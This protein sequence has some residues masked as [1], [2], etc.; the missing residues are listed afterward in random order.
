MGGA[1]YIDRAGR[2][3]SPRDGREVTFQNN[4]AIPIRPSEGS[5]YVVA[6][7]CLVLLGI[8]CPLKVTCYLL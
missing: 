2:Q 3:H 5:S 8:N 7:A 6:V 4:I 1:D